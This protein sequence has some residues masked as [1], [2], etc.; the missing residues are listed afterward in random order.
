MARASTRQATRPSGLP[1]GKPGSGSGHT[2]TGSNDAS[3]IHQVLTRARRNPFR[4]GVVIGALITL[5]VVLLVVQNTE[6][7]RLDWLFFHFNA[8]LWFILVLTAVAGAVAWE[9]TRASLRHG[10]RLRLQRKAALEAEKRA[11][12]T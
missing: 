12:P 9:L 4:L 10:R 11:R 2:P 6:S 1:E 7:A 8:Q 5:A 3:A